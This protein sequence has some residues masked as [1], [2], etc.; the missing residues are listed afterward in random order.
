MAAAQSAVI[1]RLKELHISCDPSIIADLFDIIPAA[2]G[3]FGSEIWS[4]PLLGTWDS[5]TKCKLQQYQASV[6][7]RTLGA[8]SSTSNLLALVEMGRYPLQVHW[9]VRCV[10]VWNKR[11][12]E[13]DQ[14]KHRL[15][16]SDHSST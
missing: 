15:D 14:E 12:A 2:A 6:C 10:K 8:P 11:V 4:T 3:N 16:S 7:K 1:R 5:I 13:V 9:L